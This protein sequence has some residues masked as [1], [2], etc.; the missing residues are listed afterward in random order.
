MSNSSSCSLTLTGFLF[1]FLQELRVEDYVANRKGK[2]AGTAATFGFG[3][4][5]ATTQASTAFNFGA[6]KPTGF[7]ASSKCAVLPYTLKCLSIGTHKNI[8]FPFVP[9][10]KLMFFRYPSIYADYSLAVICRK[11]GTPKIIYFPFGTMEHLLVLGVPILKHIIV[12]C[13]YK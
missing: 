10:G 1:S 3:T 4:T 13:F 6:S 8:D 11:F 12:Y 2:Q 9:N 5:P 7:G